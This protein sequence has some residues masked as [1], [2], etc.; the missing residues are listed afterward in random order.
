MEIGCLVNF[1]YSVVGEERVGDIGNVGGVVKN[2]EVVISM[3]GVYAI[4]P[5]GRE[6][7]AVWGNFVTDAGVCVLMDFGEVEVVCKVVPGLGKV[8]GERVV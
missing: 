1:I 7:E 6:G 2:G 5:R 4:E 8:V 3:R